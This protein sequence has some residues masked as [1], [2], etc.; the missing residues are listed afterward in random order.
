MIF[1]WIRLIY[2]MSPVGSDLVSPESVNHELVNHDS[3]SDGLSEASLMA[4]LPPD[5]IDET[6]DEPIA[7]LLHDPVQDDLGIDFLGED[8]TTAASLPPSEALTDDD[9]EAE[10]AGLTLEDL[11]ETD[12]LAD[13][14]EEMPLRSSSSSLMDFE[15]DPQTIE[16]SPNSEAV[17]PDL[18]LSLDF[19][20]A[21]TGWA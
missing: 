7:N 1:R 2:Q 5:L 12:P 11:P 14:P 13:L 19:L 8:P 9:F 3:F 16:R 4:G 18:D 20:D 15:A 17:E 21:P 6:P 10:L